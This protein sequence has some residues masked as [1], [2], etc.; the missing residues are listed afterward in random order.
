MADNAPTPSRLIDAKRSAKNK[1]SVIRTKGV[2]GSDFLSRLT[3]S[4]STGAASN[5]TVWM[6]EAAYR[7]HKLDWRYI[8]CE[9][10]PE[11]LKFAVH[12]AKAMGWIGF[13]C[14]MPHKIKVID[15]LDDLSDSARIIGAVNTVV[16][17]GSR[18][19]GENTDGKGFLK[20]LDAVRPVKGAK[21]LI[22]G[23]G[24]AAR[25]VAIEIALAGCKEL[26]VVNRDPG[27]GERLAEL[28]SSCTSTKT[29]F[30]PWLG[31]FQIPDDIDI[32]INCTS[33]GLP[34]RVDVDFQ[35]DTSTLLPRMTVADVI[36][37]PANT[38]FL[39]S[40]RDR[41]CTVLDGR[42]M[43]VNQ[44]CIAFKLWTGHEPNSE[45][46]K[47]ALAEIAL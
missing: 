4:F 25:A 47:A 6:I 40:A 23:A 17:S 14:S 29:C 16:I 37:N 19:L 7:F 3:G 13:N 8:N 38:K 10:N 34:P 31:R 33:I 32:V 27:R 46:F 5:P 11:N 24:G 43:L 20:S 15:F 36:A 26:H 45:V 1:N 9:V 22:F 44:A 30:S 42:G 28:V 12:G 41:G 35:V 2:L 39:Q 21:A 18:L